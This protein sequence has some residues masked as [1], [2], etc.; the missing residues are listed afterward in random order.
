MIR[1][2]AVPAKIALKNFKIKS[3]KIKRV[4]A[5]FKKLVSVSDPAKAKIKPS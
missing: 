4:G 3:E 5:K 2:R 1:R